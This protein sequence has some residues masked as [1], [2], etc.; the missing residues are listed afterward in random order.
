MNDI[1]NIDLE[2]VMKVIQNLILRII[3]KIN[4]YIV[5]MYRF[6]ICTNLQVASSTTITK[7]KQP[8]YDQFNQIGLNNTTIYYLIQH[9][10]CEII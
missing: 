7:R 1:L 9:E 5:C 3:T 8:N 2:K 4:K 6:S 10:L